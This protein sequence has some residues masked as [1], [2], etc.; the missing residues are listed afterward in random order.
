MR[1]SFR[2]RFGLIFLGFLLLVGSSVIATFWVIQT[3]NTDAT[4]I[5]LAGRQR[6]LTQQMVRLALTQPNSSELA[7][8]IGWFD[9]THD[10]LLNGGTTLDANGRVVSLPSTSTPA[11]QRQLVEISQYWQSLQLRLK[12]P[13][14]NAILQ[15]ESADLL[16]KLDNAVS[17]F[18]TQAQAK[19][20]RLRQIQLIFLVLAFLL[21]GWGYWFTRRRVTQPLAVLD[22][23]AREIGGGNLSHPLPTLPDDELG[24]LAQTLEAMRVEIATSQELLEQRVSKRTK[25]L[26]TSFEFSQEIVHQ[27]ELS[28]LLN[29]VA[30]RARDL[31]QGEAASICLLK[32]DGRT[33]ELA[34]S[35]D[36]SNDV[37]GLHQST[38]RGIAVPV[39]QEGQTVVLDNGCTNCGFL[40]HYPSASCIAAPLQVAGETLGALCVVRHQQSFDADESRALTLLANAAAI[41]FDNARLV[42]AVKRQAETNAALAE[43]ERMA[44]DLH[45]NLAQTLSFLKLKTE[46]VEEMITTGEPTVAIDELRRMETAVMTA[47][48]QVRTALT[49]LRQRSTDEVAL[50]QKLQECVNEFQEQTG[51]TAVLSIADPGAFNLPSV[52]QRQALYIVSEALT[53]TRRHAQAS[54]VRVSVTC[55]NGA[56]QFAIKD[57]G[58]GFEAGRVRSDY[59][60]GLSIMNTRA[61]RS[62]GQ[63]TV[64][65]APG[66]GTQVVA[67][68]PLNNKEA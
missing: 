52:T 24:Q 6:M 59:H 22:A 60:L 21:L 48:G 26:M 17:A 10:A 28:Q 11:I 50:A 58:Q 38:Q 4:V 51:V 64:H 23:A 67:T 27:L 9:R 66:E 42:A 7:E 35:S 49:G 29:S 19:I 20:N 62:G 56:A 30:N 47:Y 37:I 41:A 55:T 18:E 12:P 43:R 53:N 36:I 54:R 2:T 65:S 13:I 34:A 57:D 3:Q 15:T 32:S 44:A 45:D 39:I 40:H 61:E 25:E 1:R 31:M 33:L 14:D 5:N 46:R 16:I 68:F 8:T 63:L